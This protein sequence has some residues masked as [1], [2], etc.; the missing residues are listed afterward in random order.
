[1]PLPGTDADDGFRHLPYRFGSAA[2]GF[3]V[4][5]RSTGLQVTDD[6]PRFIARGRAPSSGRAWDRSVSHCCLD[7]G[8]PSIAQ[9]GGRLQVSSG[10]LGLR[11]EGLPGSLSASGVAFNLLGHDQLSTELP[12][13]CFRAN[14]GNEERGSV[15][16]AADG[17][18]FLVLFAFWLYALYDAITTVDVHVRNL[19]KVVWV[20]IIIFLFE[21]GAA[22]WFLLGRPSKASFSD[23]S[24]KY[25][26]Y[27]NPLDA[28][29]LTGLSP[30]VRDREERARMQVW[31]EQLRRREEEI[32]KR[33]GDHD[34]GTGT[35]PSPSDE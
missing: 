34:P 17:L 27:A 3:V 26:A 21:I 30:V 9:A 33:L 7:G 31:E 28:A 24:G 12:C 25:R 23:S 20:I 18:V 2:E 6:V 16:L 19:P 35:A 5:K 29:D 15:F 1:M 8:P 32:A 10:D 11:G 4:I 13:I 22:A 14:F